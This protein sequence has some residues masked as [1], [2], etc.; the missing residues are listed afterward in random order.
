MNF[1]DQINQYRPA[2]AQEEQDRAVMLDFVSKYGESSLLRSCRAAHFTS[3]AFILSP[4]LSS[5][6]L[7][8]HALRGTWSWPG[9]HADGESDLLLTALRETKEETGVAQIAPLSR[10]I[11]SLDIFP[12][13]AH[14]KNGA[15]VNAHLHFSAGYC[16]ICSS[17][18]ALQAQPGETTAVR[19]FPLSHFT[20]KNFS[21]ADARLY[22]KLISRAKTMK[23]IENE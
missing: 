23:E 9:G 21:E 2:D 15:Y 14:C 10:S 17:A 3:S 8:R 19:W 5:V 13:P 20:E 4:D 16:L 11:A 18:Q 1:C 6:L 12:V 22:Q 7:I